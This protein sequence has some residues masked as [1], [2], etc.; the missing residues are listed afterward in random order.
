M[1]HV[2]FY[3]YILDSGIFHGSLSFDV[4]EATKDVTAFKE[5]E[6]IQFDNKSMGAI[7]VAVSEFHTCILYP[8]KFTILMQPPGLCNSADAE[9][10][11]EILQVPISSI[12]IAYEELLSSKG[13]PRGLTKDTISKEIFMYTSSSI[14]RLIVEDETRD[15]WRLYLEKALDPAISKTEYFEIAQN[16]CNVRSICTVIFTITG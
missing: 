9:K 14:F 11:S 8:E 10:K 7:S 12:K 3:S 4:R 2:L 1:S 16:L 5:C 6:I 15:V 13:E